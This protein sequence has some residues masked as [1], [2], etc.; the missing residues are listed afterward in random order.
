MVRILFEEFEEITARTTDPKKKAAQILK[1]VRF[2]LLRQAYMSA[3]FAALQITA[4]ELTWLGEHVAK[5][6]DLVC[7]VRE[8]RLSAP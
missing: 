5:L 2:E 6:Q 3:I 4:E 7:D 1:R 8:P